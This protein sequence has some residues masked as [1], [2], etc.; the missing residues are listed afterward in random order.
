MLFESQGSMML[1]MA[2]GG[3]SLQ[4]EVDPADTT[5]SSSGDIR[6]R[7]LRESQL[8]EFPTA[9]SVHLNL[10]TLDGAEQSYASPSRV[11]PVPAASVSEGKAQEQPERIQCIG[12]HSNDPQ[13]HGAIGVTR[14]SSS[15]VAHLPPRAS[16]PAP[17]IE[18]ANT[19]A[20][21][22]G[23]SPPKVPGKAIQ[24]ESRQRA[25][26]RSKRHSSVESL[27]SFIGDQGPRNAG[28][29]I[30][31]RTRAEEEAERLAKEQGFHPEA[32]R[33]TYAS[34]SKRPQARDEAREKVLLENVMADAEGARPC[35]KLSNLALTMKF[36]EITRHLQTPGVRCHHLPNSRSF[37]VAFQWPR[38]PFSSK[39][40]PQT[41]IHHPQDPQAS[42]PHLLNCLRLWFLP[43]THLGQTH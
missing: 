33:T 7:Q 22:P 16:P 24:A 41:Q 11:M 4:N 9:Q 13:R 35:L 26:L 39:P 42:P 19:L 17:N 8:E 20:P 15:G 6:L 31:Q 5:S 28:D 2:M 23:M 25:T 30:R 18:A 21:K 37:T 29:Y 32:P 36:Q 27:D 14:E 34:P 3:N 38:V 1:R 43:G 40:P 10:E 12:E